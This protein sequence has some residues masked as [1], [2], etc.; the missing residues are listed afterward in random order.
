VVAPTREQKKVHVEWTKI[1]TARNGNEVIAL[2]LPSSDNFV[3]LPVE[4]IEN[5]PPGAIG[6]VG[7]LTKRETVIPLTYVEN[8]PW[9]LTY[10]K[11]TEEILYATIK[12]LCP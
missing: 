1:G 9:V 4:L 7:V 6:V 8:P 5:L 3:C 10:W 11:G 2:G 12:G